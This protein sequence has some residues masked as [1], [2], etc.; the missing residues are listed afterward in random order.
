MWGAWGGEWSSSSGRVSK[1]RTVSAKAES[2]KSRCLK[3]FKRQETGSAVGN[4]LKEQDRARPVRRPV[5]RTQA[6]NCELF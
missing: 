6:R 3:I 4:G 1:Q 2:G 5:A